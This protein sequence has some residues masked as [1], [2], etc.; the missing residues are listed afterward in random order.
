[1]NAHQN[2]W[3]NTITIKQRHKTPQKTKTDFRYRNITNGA[4][5]GKMGLK[6]LQNFINHEN[7]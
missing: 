3:E 7:K 6:I 4:F 5:Y 2:T 1:M